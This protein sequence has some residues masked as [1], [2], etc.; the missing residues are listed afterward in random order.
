MT[1]KKLFDKDDALG[2]TRI[3]HY[4]ADKDEA[5]I[6]TRQDVSQIIEENKQEYAQID[7]RARWGEWTRVA[8]IPMSIY[9]KMKAE[10]KL[11]DEAYMKR[12]LN[13]PDNKY[14][15]TRSGEV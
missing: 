10:G 2:I 15:R 7:E 3:W 13:D 8:S 4:D 14:F 6:E 5:T 9:F 12:W 11:D 1:E